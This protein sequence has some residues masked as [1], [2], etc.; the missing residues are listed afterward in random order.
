M[1]LHVGVVLAALIL[2]ASLASIELGLSAA[3]I[4]IGLGVVA[5][6][7]F[8]IDRPGWVI[9]LAGFGGIL[10][11]FLAGAE[12][13]LAVM[14]ERAKE[15]F[16]IGG[17]SFLAPF[18]GAL[19]LC[20]YALGWEW[21]AAQIAGIAL[22][23]TS[24]AVV[25]AV[26]VETGLTRTVIGKIIMASTFVTDFGTA[27]GLT[28][29]FVRPGLDML[30]FALA[31]L[32]A[33]VGAPIVFPR[34]V[35]RYGDRV[36]EPEIKLLFLVLVALMWMAHRAASHALLPAFVL[37]LAL[38]RFFHE[39]RELQRK[40]RVVAFAFI[41]PIFFLNG[42]MAISIPLLGANLAL[43]GILLA[44]KLATKFAGV[45]PISLLFI[46]R[47]ATYTTLLMSTG[48]TMGTISSLF[49]YQQGVIDQAQFSV[50]VAVV[51][52][53]AILPTFL[54]QRFFHPKH[55]LEALGSEVEPEVLDGTSIS[56]PGAPPGPSSQDVDPAMIP[57]AGSE[58]GEG[59]GMS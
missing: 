13:D 47:E 2:V 53:S 46:R 56:P 32:A 31:S 11:T 1:D 39:H 15:S 30:W 10:L 44:V 28:L 57:P 17:L 25:Y 55:A 8:G 49:G 3:V 23:T 38:S 48:L 41:T 27:A 52:A 9:Y 51:V 19:L 40:I 50:L 58:V 7:L 36:I 33:I 21:P 43:F 54:A 45:Y 29:L 42:G 20:R 59:A 18:L 34:F 6:N 35:R 5:G 14:R 26:L 4:E 37:G 24:L 16:L 22:S 12:V